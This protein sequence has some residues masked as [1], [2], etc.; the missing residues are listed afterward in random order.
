MYLPGM[1]VSISRQ[2]VSVGLG[3]VQSCLGS[4]DSLLYEEAKDTSISFLFVDMHDSAILRYY[5][6]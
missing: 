3:L 2:I 4:S 1:L 5:T 6:L